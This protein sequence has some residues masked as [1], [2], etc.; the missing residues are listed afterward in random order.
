MMK[1][2]EFTISDFL[3]EPSFRSWVL[4]N[5]VHAAA[6]WEEWMQHNPDK[7]DTVRQARQWLQ[8][9]GSATYTPAPEDGPA[10]WSRIL[11]TIERAALQGG[12]GN[13]FAIPPAAARVRNRRWL[14]YTA[15]LTGMAISYTAAVLLFA[16]PKVEQQATAK[17]EMKTV[18]LPDS[19]EVK[20]NVNSTLRYAK[21][22]DAIAPREVWISGEA[23][24]TVTHKYNNQR[25]VVHTP[26]MDVQVTGTAFN[27]NTRRVKTQV[28]LDNGVVKLALRQHESA[29]PIIMKPGDMV[30]YSVKTNELT[31]TRVNPEVYSSWQRKKLLF[32]DTPISE[33]IKSLQDNLGITIALQ[34]ES[35][36][37][38]TFT[39]AIPMDNI[40]VFFKIL[41]KS[42]HVTVTKTG[43]DTYR[44][45]QQ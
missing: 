41:S 22:W 16:R 38:Q 30:T 37:D 15:I 26:D 9:L 3:E 28:V 43:T 31:N 2:R 8:V 32:T 29:M 17:R 18:F 14:P 11:G 44:I 45:S 7:V 39:G 35:L 24:F 40:E 1:F 33:V 13:L 20:L 4:E 23:F 34:D 19:S 5:D 42:L 12:K 6:F 10:I 25:F 27:V 36:G 21:A